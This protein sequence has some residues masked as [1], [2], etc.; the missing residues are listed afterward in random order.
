MNT[1]VQDN[2]ATNA[3]M[4]P[5]DLRSLCGPHVLLQLASVSVIDSCDEL[6]DVPFVQA[7][8]HAIV[9]RDDVARQ[10][11]VPR[12]LSMFW[13][14]L[15]TLGLPAIADK[16]Q[17]CGVAESSRHGLHP[18]S[19]DTRRHR[20]SGTAARLGPPRSFHSVKPGWTEGLSL[21]ARTSCRSSR[22]R[23]FPL[24][25]L[26]GK[27]VVFEALA[28]KNV[29]QVGRRRDQQT[30]CERPWKPSNHEHADGAAAAEKACFMWTCFWFRKASVAPRLAVHSGRCHKTG[31]EQWFTG[32]PT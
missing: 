32:K 6:M 1:D 16:N 22:S 12:H 14:L 23:H 5:C 10:A 24:I 31:E 8:V 4:S 3:A 30:R 7:K 28:E 15:A 18:C 13:T 25:K 17:G 27:L 19:S 9:A 20:T 26:A 29:E 11:H 2:G 21:P